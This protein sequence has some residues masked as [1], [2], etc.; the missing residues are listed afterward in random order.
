MLRDRSK[1]PASDMVELERLTDV[2][3]ALE[4]R[5]ETERLAAVFA[6][7]EAAKQQGYVSMET[8]AVSPWEHLINWSTLDDDTVL[9]PNEPEALLYKVEDGTW[10]LQAVMYLLPLRYNY[11]NT[12]AIAGGNGLWHVH[13]TVCLKGDPLEDPSLGVVDP[14]CAKGPNAPQSLMIHVWVQPNPC[15]PFAPLLTDTA[16]IVN[17]ALGGVDEN[18][19]VQQCDTSLT[20]RVWPELT[21]DGSRP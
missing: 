12:P 7:P 8:L 9:D 10:T 15:G 4:W 1:L 13:R 17:K 3:A 2:D 20:E 11:A 21:A 18:G 6:D 19:N 16:D 5:N 14:L